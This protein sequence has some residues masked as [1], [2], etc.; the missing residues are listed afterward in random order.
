MRAA[1][2]VMVMS[3]WAC[4][5]TAHQVEI[6]A[7]PPKMTHGTLAGPLCGGTECKCRDLN[8]P[9]DGGAGVPSD[10][11]HK[12]FEV[13]LNSPQALWAQIGTTVLYKSAEHAEA[14][15]YVD[16]PAGDTP[17]QL[18]MSDKDGGA[19]SWQIRELGTKT[20]SYYDTFTFNC[21]VPGVC[22]FEQLDAIKQE[23]ASM[24]RNLHDL[25]GSTKL[26]SVSWDHSKAPDGLHPTDVQVTLH[27]DVYKFAPWKEHGDPT[28]G[29]G[30]P[31]AD[32]G[33]DAPSGDDAA[34][35]AA[36]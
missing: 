4:S 35:S 28:C 27:L 30:K 32:V 3:S 2:F 36:P 25:C 29:K 10:A 26:Q 7:P 22:S 33:S 14:C 9:G 31:S 8:A 11:A 19:G 23:Y 34:G 5:G 20:K 6:G 21:G 1:L 24:K 16:L 15:F 17:V 18:R 12:R 13:R